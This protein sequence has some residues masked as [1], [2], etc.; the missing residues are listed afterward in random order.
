MG[1]RADAVLYEL[2]NEKEKE[3]T[4]LDLI[5]LHDYYLKDTNLDFYSGGKGGQGVPTDMVYGGKMQRSMGL[6]ISLISR[7][8]RRTPEN[9]EP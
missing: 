2:G 8:K 5:E 9:K 7:E 6:P 1:K 3:K 4:L